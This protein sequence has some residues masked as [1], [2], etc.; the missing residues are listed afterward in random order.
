MNACVLGATGFIGGQIARAAASAGW[1][2]RAVRRNPNSTGAIGDLEVDWARAD[3]GDATSLVEAMRGCDVLF[4]AASAYP[5]GHG[6]RRIAA[7]VCQ[8][9]EEMQ[10][11]LSAAR[12]AGVRRVIYTSSLTTVECKLPLPLGEGWGEGK[13]GELDESNFYRPGSANSAYYDAKFAMEQIALKTHDIDVVTLLPTAVIGPGDIK[14]TTSV[15]VRDAAL[16][17]YPLYFD[18]PL[19]VVDGRD[20]ARS[21]IAAVAQ[22]RAGERY[23]LGGYNLSLFKVLS[24]VARIVGKSPPRI[25]VPRDVLKVLISITDALPFVNM[26]D[27]IRMFEFW[28][29]MS[30]AKAKRE[31]GH[32]VR[33]F[34][35]T[36]R[37]TLAWFKQ[38]NML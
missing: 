4:H 10:H 21:H 3:L 30:S 23:I 14:P 7:A 13:G 32:T 28:N 24:T 6:S 38:H 1:H 19:N 26:P 36:V 20:V 16:G 5:N 2:V 29:S 9:A 33:P 17:R 34:E 25:Q 27:H 31:L 11:V 22:G 8:A 37:D 18:A 35:E 12:T 15:V